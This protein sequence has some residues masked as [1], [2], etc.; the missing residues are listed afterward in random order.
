ML[1]PTITI[2][3]ILGLNNTIARLL[4]NNKLNNFVPTA[5]QTEYLIF[6]NYN[7]SK[8][9]KDF[10]PASLAIFESDNGAKLDFTADL[11]RWLALHSIIRLSKHLDATMTE[12]FDSSRLE[13]LRLHIRT[14]EFS[15][16][17]RL[18]S[19]L[20]V[21]VMDCLADYQD[22]NNRCELKRKLQALALK[23]DGTTARM[24]EA[25]VSL[26]L[27]M[28]NKSGPVGEKTVENLLGAVCGSIFKISDDHN[29]HKFDNVLFAGLHPLER[30]RPDYVVEVG[31]V[32]PFINLDVCFMSEVE[33]ITLPSTYSDFCS[34]GVF[35]D[36]LY[37]LSLLYEGH[38]VQQ[39]QTNLFDYA[40][41]K[42]I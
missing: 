42:E 36:S 7:V 12:A 24:L 20:K 21:E 28:T 19:T 41:L 38:C 32:D 11:S 26:L 39:Q 6:K 17:V 10:S 13:A 1:N 22:N 15:K 40:A 9:L 2:L 27:K 4:Q 16:P 5:H 25:L 29:P 31:S 33:R 3:R 23:N 34:F 18:S 14:K 30:R 8:A 35:L 37:D